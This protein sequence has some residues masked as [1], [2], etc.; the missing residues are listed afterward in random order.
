[1]FLFLSNV[2]KKKKTNQQTMKQSS[3]FSTANLFFFGGI[4]FQLC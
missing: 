3:V 4:K 1:M 2:K